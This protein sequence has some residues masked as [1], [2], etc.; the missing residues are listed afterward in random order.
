MAREVL[1]IR[2]G[3]MKIKRSS[4]IYFS[5]WLNKNKQVK[6]KEILQEYSTIVNYFINKYEYQ[7]PETNKYH[8]SLA[9]YIQ[10]G[11]KETDTWLTARLVKNAF[12]EGYGMVQSAKSN[13]ENRKDK[14]Y[15]KPIHYA[16]KAILS[17]TI[18]TQFDL[19]QTKDFDFNVT[20][21]S[22]GN[23]LKISIP[24]KCHKQFNKWNE[25]G[26]RSKSIILTNYYNMF[27]FE[28]DT[29]KKK[30]ESK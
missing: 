30:E 6:I 15:F 3:I 28:I 22:I 5:K 24:L 16:K 17:E 1:A 26:K 25:L 7:I 2:N 11:I 12:A 4:K 9:K 10:R 23:K 13:A 29:G 27:S 18:N 21:G 20:L 19:T 14:K 8:L